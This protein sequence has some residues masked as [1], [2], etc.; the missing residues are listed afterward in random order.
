VVSTTIGAEGLEVHPPGDI[1]IAD[2]PRQFAE[3]CLEL[4]DDPAARCR[5][6]CA[7][8]EMVNSRFSWVQVS[9]CFERILEQG[10]RLN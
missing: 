1:R 9:R 7:A 5:V 3:H 10:P 6:A 4:L 8:W 2:A